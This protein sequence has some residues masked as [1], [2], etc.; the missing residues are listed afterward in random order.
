MTAKQI[1]KALTILFTWSL[2]YYGLLIISNNKISTTTEEIIA[3]LPIITTITATMSLAMFTYL[4]NITKDLTELRNEVN[5]QKYTIAHGEI[6][7]LKTEVIHN[8]AFIV[9]LLI[10]ERATKVSSTIIVDLSQNTNKIIIINIA[11]SLRASFFTTSTYTA[12]IQLNG[13]LTAIKYR[14]VIA[15][16]RK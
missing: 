15:N 1:I 13:F 5:K 7:K 3:S 14:E 2:V 16:N 10:L 8:G 11:L 6:S 12:I 9:L 4:D